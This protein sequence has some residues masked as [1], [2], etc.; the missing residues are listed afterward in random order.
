MKN[1]MIAAVVI[2]LLGM[3]FYGSARLKLNNQV[4]ED[5]EVKVVDQTVSAALMSDHLPKN[6][7][8]T[9]EFDT[10]N[11]KDIYLA[12]GCFWGL[13]AYL[14]RIPGVYDATVGYANGLTENPSYED[15]I[16]RNSG[17]AETVHLRY[18]PKL[19]SLET[20]I[21]YYFKVIDP[22]S[23]NKQGN[24]RGTQ[25]RTGIY[26]TSE[27][28]EKLVEALIEKEQMD[29]DDKIVVEVLPLEHYYLAEEYHQDYLEKNP[30]GYCH[31][32][33]NEVTEGVSN[34]VKPSDSELRD[35]LTDLQYDVTQNGGTERPFENE[36]WDNKE[37]GIYV[38]IVT[39]EPLFSS[40]D[41]YDSGT[42]WPSFTRPIEESVI[43]EVVDKK[44]GMNRTEVKSLSGDSH[45]GHVFNDGPVDQGGLRYC[46]NSASLKFIPYEDMEAMGYGHLMYLFE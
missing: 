30:N 5:M 44:F 4:A 9:L 20:V 39:G 17:H 37:K 41:K 29:Y 22:T 13:E 27:N 15:L 12:G 23:L 8:N 28:E 42:G 1:M 31:I 40:I 32:D 19:V 10:E 11:L 33:I 36:Y 7:N 2:G 18:D 35:M 45:L 16:Y 34:Y 21:N 26:F 38:D 43:M 14:T 3:V 25:Y 6:P 24:D 46:I